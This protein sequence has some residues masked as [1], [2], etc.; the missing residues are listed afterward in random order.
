MWST[1][2]GAEVM[3]PLATPVLGGM[4]S[5][6]LH[7]LIV[8]PVLFYWL[9]ERRLGLKE[10]GLAP[11]ARPVATPRRVFAAVGAIVVILASV[12][13]V[14]AWRSRHAVET[15]AGSPVQQIRSGNVTIVLLSPTG[16][17][18]LGRN[19]YAIE[20]R[21]ANG[22]L[23]DVGSVRSSG[24]MTM[25]GMAM[26]GGVR[27]SRTNVAGR[28]QATAEFGMAGAWKMAIEWDGA[29]GRGSVDF[30]GTVR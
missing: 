4:V 3:K 18:H 26:S 21:G 9:Q 6:L 24:N 11:A 20:F 19:S 7:V 15:P 2:V 16:T 10:E 13:L 1:R 27:V 28:Y 8:T 14:M 5:S 17:L 25:P 30:E 23:M 12:A 29:A 22:A